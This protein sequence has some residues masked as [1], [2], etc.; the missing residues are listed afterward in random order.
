M[1]KLIALSVVQSLLLVTSQIFLKLAMERTGRFSFTWNF[2]REALLNWQLACSG[3]S[4]AGAT[5]LWVYILRHFEFS[6]AYPLISISYVW[7]IL[8]ASL[9]FHE[10]IP[11]TRW[12]GTGLIILG[13]MLVA[14]K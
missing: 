8:A 4:I 12:C 1:W 5:L 6:I 3:I 13:V 7:G 10:T 14:H 11:L 2:F 9:I